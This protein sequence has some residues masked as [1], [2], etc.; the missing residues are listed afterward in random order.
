LESDRK[1][2]PQPYDTPSEVGLSVAASQGVW[3]LIAILSVSFGVGG[4]SQLAAFLVAGLELAG[5]ILSGFAG[6]TFYWLV[7]RRNVHVSQQQLALTSA[8][9]TA[10]SRTDPS[11]LNTFLPLDS[12][13]R[14]LFYYSHG[15][16]EK[17]AILWGLL[18]AIPYAGWLAMIYALWFLSSDLKKHEL[19]EDSI[20]HEFDRYVQASGGP[21]LPVR[22]RWS[23]FREAIGLG[24]TCIVFLGI[25]LFGW[26]V[27]L[28]AASLVPVGLSTGP[29]LA[30]ITILVLGSLGFV[31]VSNIWLY[32]TIT[33]PDGHF[34]F[35]RAWEAFLQ[36]Q[37]G[38]STA[39]GA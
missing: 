12:A 14:S 21:V 23:P 24:V 2:T 11:N 25:T 27:A 17:S 35:H 8:L 4:L 6:Y 13:E 29:N 3:V 9:T 26:F 5:F 15:S 33:D 19:S 37:L 28:A 30:A 7:N 22:Q 36:S 34:A 32:W 1:G 20:M 16:G 31:A 18:V 39:S 10:K 38:P